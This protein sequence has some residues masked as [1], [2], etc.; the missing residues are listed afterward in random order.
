MKK[1]IL[2]FDT[3]I[4]IIDHDMLVHVDYREWIETYATKESVF[5]ERSYLDSSNI[6]IVK[7]F[8]EILKI[9]VKHN[10]NLVILRTFHNGKIYYARV[11]KYQ[12]ETVEK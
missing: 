10:K 8:P 3:K 2:P 1:Y 9:F 6:K 11:N 12:L 4:E 7:H 5:D